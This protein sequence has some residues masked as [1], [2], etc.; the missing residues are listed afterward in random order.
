M[1]ALPSSAVG[2]NIRAHRTFFGR[3]SAESARSR[4]DDTALLLLFPRARNSRHSGVQWSREHKQQ[5]VTAQ[6]LPQLDDD[7]VSCISREGGGESQFVRV[8]LCQ[9]TP[10]PTCA[11]AA[12]LLYFHHDRNGPV[13]QS[14]LRRCVSPKRAYWSFLCRPKQH[15]TSD[16]FADIL[17]SS[18]CFVSATAIL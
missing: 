18:Q 17:D 8:F 9:R 2:S 4:A 11:T 1:F 5:Q 6:V 7:V 13:Y 3:P 16:D 10:C 14:S 12:W 15:S